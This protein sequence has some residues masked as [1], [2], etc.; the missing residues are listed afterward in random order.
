MSSLHP[1]GRVRVALRRLQPVDLG[2]HHAVVEDR[3]QPRHLRA[4]ASDRTVPVLGRRPVSGDPRRS[5]AVGASTA[6]RPPTAIRTRSVP[7]TDGGGG[8]V[9]ARFNY[10]RNSVKAVV[11][12]YDGTM[13]LYIVDTNDPIVQ[14]YPKA[15]PS[16]FS[17]DDDPPRDL[18][19]HFRYPEDMFRTQTNMWGRYHLDNPD[20]FYTNANAWTVAPDPGTQTQTAA[21]TATTVNARHPGAAVAHRPDPAVLRAAEP[22]GRG[23][24]RASCSSARSCRRRATTSR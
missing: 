21:A 5:H 10:V 9:R 6:T 17:K 22:A 19:E 14:A 18:A 15:F 1:Q 11:D 8:P 4:R 23:G 20:A 16:L 3:H 12:A 13:K 7:I 2:Q 24:S